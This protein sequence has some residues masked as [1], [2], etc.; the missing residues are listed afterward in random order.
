MNM[1]NGFGIGLGWLAVLFFMTGCGDKVEQGKYTAEQMKTIPFPNRADLPKPAG[2]MTLNVESEAITMKDLAIPLEQQLKPLAEKSNPDAFSQAARPAFREALRSRVTDILLYKEAK[3]KAPED[4]DDPLDKAVE[5]ELSRFL[6]SYGNNRALAEHALR[7]MGYDWK[8]FRDF[9]RK[10][11][12]TQSYLSKE[13]TDKRPIAHSDMVDYYNQ[14]RDQ[15]CVEGT[16]QFRVI[17]IIPEKLPSE[18]VDPNETP[19]KAS[20]RLTVEILDKLN[21]GADFAKLAEQ[22]SQGPLASSGGLWRPITVGAGSLPAPYEILEQKAVMMDPNQ[23]TGPLTAK[24]HLFILR[25]ENKKET[26]CKT[27][28][29]VQDGIDQQFQF[30]FRKQQYEKLINQL[31]ARVDVVQMDGFL[32]QCI[33]DAYAM[34]NGKQ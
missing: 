21:A 13:F 18:L 15:F 3:K 6:A 16:V 30:E 17:D 5:S 23:V 34:W 25:L 10:L 27:F 2:G 33:T 7:T 12:L 4:I 8:T 31:V 32:D 9:Q 1:K 14:H 19:E 20:V 26:V 11:I 28:E 29:E 22:Y 24:G